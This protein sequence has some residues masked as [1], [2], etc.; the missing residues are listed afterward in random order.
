MLYAG[1]FGRSIHG[2]NLDDIIILNTKE[3]IFTAKDFTVYP[4]PVRT[5]FSINH[6]I[7]S[8][9]II[10]IYDI[11]G[12]KIKT[13]FQGNLAESSN[14]SFFRDGIYFLKIQSGLHSVIKKLIVQ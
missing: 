4:N 14:R 7:S 6:N 3:T 9:G 11:T 1:T 8:E 13:V 10:K 5:E 2:Y 12:K